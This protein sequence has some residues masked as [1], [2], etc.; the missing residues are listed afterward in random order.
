MLLVIVVLWNCSKCWCQ[1]QYNPLRGD[2]L[3]SIDLNYIKAAN[4]K[5]LKLKLY[6][7]I[8]AEQDSIIYLQKIKY[9]ALNE[10][11]VILQNRVIDISKANNN[12]NNN[13]NNIK[14][15]NKYLLGCSAVCA[16]AF[17]VLLLIK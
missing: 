3:V 11:V 7:D 6:K 5:L 16:T 15:T 8:V 1:I 9:N 12:L 13:I 10:E 14:R 2:T 4:S 17:I